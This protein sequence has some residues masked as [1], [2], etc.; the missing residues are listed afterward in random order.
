MTDYKLT[1]PHTDVLIIGAGIAGLLAAT[2]LKK[3][4]HR[5]NV[6]DKGRGVGGRLATRRIE[7]AIFDHGAQ[8]ITAK[9]AR[10]VT[11]I[12][13]WEKAG[14]VSEWYRNSNSHSDVHARWR[15]NPA[16]TAI[17]KYLAKDL[18]VLLEKRAVSVVTD[19]GRFVSIFENN[20]KIYSA[21]V[22]LTAPVPQSIE[23]IKS[24][25][26]TLT[27]QIKNQLESIT[28]E[29]CIAVMA[30][31]KGPVKI[32]SP[33]GFAPQS[34]P[35]G[36][37]ADNYMKKIST[38]PAVTIHA[39]SAFS[40]EN[41]NRDKKEVGKELLEAAEPFLGSDIVDY[42]VHGWRYSK[43]ISV[44]ENPSV[45]LSGSPPLIIAG[46]AFGGPSVEGAALSG[47]DAAASLNKL[48]ENT[49]SK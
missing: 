44:S 42:Q 27:S 8:F 45:I 16:M 25:G 5:V 21:S 34:G 7:Q 3:S 17:A 4:G 2:E 26:I 1:T 18:S 24:G 40:L 46:D 47:W 23:L 30:I 14:V 12:L 20:E 32:P 9:H 41:W 39:T 37:I 36:F 49:K 10:F 22:I 31:T 28:Y 13:E 15:G 48:L 19:S 6:V 33:G 38:I 43:P 29:P 35:I 11:A